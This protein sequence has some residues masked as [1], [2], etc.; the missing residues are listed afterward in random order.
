M[1]NTTPDTLQIR[2][3]RVVAVMVG[4]LFII[5]SLSYMAGS[6]ILESYLNAP[7]YLAKASAHKSHIIIG[8]FL[9]YVCDIALVVIPVLLLR[10]LKSSNGILAYGYLGFRIIDSLIYIIGALFPLL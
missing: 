8:V 3:M 9:E 4:A 7:D 1:T 6:T 10:I 2:A 5:S